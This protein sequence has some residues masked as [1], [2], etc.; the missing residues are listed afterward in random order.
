MERRLGRGLD[1]LLSGS[2]SKNRQE[3]SATGQRSQ[4]SKPGSAP[5]L[6]QLD[7]HGVPADAEGVRSLPVTSMRPNALQPRLHFDEEAIQE[8][9]NSL[10][11]H[12]VLQAVVVRQNEGQEGYELIAGERRWRAAQLA[13]IEQLPALIKLGV[14][15]EQMIEL[16]MVENVQRRDLDPIERAKGYQRMSEKLNL[17]QTE[18]AERV[19]LRRSSISNQIR[20]LDLAPTAQVL[21]SEGTLSM[22]HARALLGLPDTKAQEKLAAEVVEHGISVREVEK[23]VREMGGKKKSATAS[24]NGPLPGILAGSSDPKPPAAWVGEMERRL[25]ERL[26]TKVEVRNQPGYS[27]QIVLHYDDR[28]TLER[29][30]DLLSPPDRI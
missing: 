3:P 28:E 10:T 18:V 25:R 1:S 4:V 11:A 22:G 7:E 19:G 23:L 2:S 17:T 29:I 30:A 21:L 9:A 6:P 26:G 12:G 15:D 20:L 8:L 16:A 27:G 24:K 14:T 5:P 13:G